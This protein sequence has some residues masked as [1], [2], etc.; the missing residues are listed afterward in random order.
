M[1][2]QANRARTWSS[3]SD[4]SHAPLVWSLFLS[5]TPKGGI[6]DFSFTVKVCVTWCGVLKAV[7]VSLV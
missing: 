5:L 2:S 1:K 3:D 6:P 4:I 7:K